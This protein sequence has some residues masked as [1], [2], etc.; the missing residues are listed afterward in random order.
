M[1]SEDGITKSRMVEEGVLI[2]DPAP[3]VGKS[4]RARQFMIKDMVIG[5]VLAEKLARDVLVL[6]IDEDKGMLQ[7]KYL[8][9]GPYRGGVRINGVPLHEVDRERLWLA[10][11]ICWLLSSEWKLQLKTEQ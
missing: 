8:T 9:D 11:K 5:E 1:N 3:V 7:V 6:Q 4:Y 2:S 10:G